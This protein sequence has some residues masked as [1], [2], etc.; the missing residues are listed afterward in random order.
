M[1]LLLL[2]SSV[3]A[4]QEWGKEDTARALNL[5]STTHDYSKLSVNVCT[6]NEPLTTK[7]QNTV[8]AG[9]TKHGKTDHGQTCPSDAVKKLLNSL[10]HWICKFLCQICLTAH[11]ANCWI[12]FYVFCRS[13]DW[14]FTKLLLIMFEDSCPGLLLPTVAPILHR[15]SFCV[16]QILLHTR[17]GYYV[18]KSTSPVAVV[19]TLLWQTAKTVNP[20]SYKTV[21][22]FVTPR[23]DA[24]AR[25]T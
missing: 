11:S 15:L 6:T 21:K 17:S 12:C 4:S 16:S 19:P 14:L 9:G 1:V 20:Q 2:A 8:E 22:Q 24:H 3:P 18:K 25:A 13:S 5:S 10:E 7:E 23:V